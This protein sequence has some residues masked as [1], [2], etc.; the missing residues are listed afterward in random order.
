MSNP[1]LGVVSLS[2]IYVAKKPPLASLTRA[3]R[4]LRAKEDLARAVIMSV[5]GDEPLT[6]MEDVV[7]VIVPRIA[8]EADSLVLCCASPSS[9]LLVLPDMALVDHLVGL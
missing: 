1:L 8:V 7:A 9:Y 2:K 3:S 6:A 5:I 4:S